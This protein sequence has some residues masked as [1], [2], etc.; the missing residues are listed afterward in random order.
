MLENKNT[1]KAT[2]QKKIRVFAA[3][4]TFLLFGGFLVSSNQPSVG[5][6]KAMDKE[7]QYLEFIHYEDNKIVDTFRDDEL[8]AKGRQVCK[9]LD[10]NFT[11]NQAVVFLA[12][13]RK[14]KPEVVSHYAERVIV[15]AIA[16]FCNRHSALVQ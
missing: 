7:A 3:V 13:D 1:E 2:R 9:V 14:E 12:V 4:F 8:V 15:G 10:E 11:I 5:E 16:F 6:M